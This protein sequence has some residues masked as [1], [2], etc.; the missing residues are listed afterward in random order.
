M[1]VTKISVEGI[2]PV[3]VICTL[4]HGFWLQVISMGF[5][6][7][8]NGVNFP[9]PDDYDIDVDNARVSE[10]V[11]MSLNEYGLNC[12]TYPSVQD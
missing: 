6:H 7:S 5:F 1:T 2:L 3:N 9:L 8:N 12:L 10:D 4:Y 11:N